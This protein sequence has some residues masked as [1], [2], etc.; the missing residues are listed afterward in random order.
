M[1]QFFTTSRSLF[2]QTC[3]LVFILL[4][5]GGCARQQNSRIMEVT[6]YCGCSDCCGWERGSWSYLKLDFWNRY[7]SAGPQKGQ[8]Y[9]GLTAHGTK[10][11][12]PEEGLFSM[13]SLS[14]PWMIPV[15]T[16]LFP[17]YLLPED[18]T[19]A[20]DTTY[21]PFGTRMYVP[22]Y[23]WGVVEDRGGAIKGQNRLDI[24]YDSHEEA[25]HWGRKKVRVIIEAP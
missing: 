3:L 8:T 14:R 9:S 7:V 17:W 20:A 19:I 4:L 12:E 10:P 25:L 21:Y 1:T 13:D 24:F 23:G 11:G 16:I 18:G 15:R 2:R 6:A 22:G 5:L